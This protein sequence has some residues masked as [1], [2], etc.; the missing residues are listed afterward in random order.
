MRR[1]ICWA[2]TRQGGPHVGPGLSCADSRAGLQEG[3][4]ASGQS[5]WTHRTL[6][7]KGARNPN[8]SLL[9]PP[10]NSEVYWGLW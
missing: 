1:P 2:F 9:T 7:L 3:G 8:L 5:A 4:E 10:E 6:L